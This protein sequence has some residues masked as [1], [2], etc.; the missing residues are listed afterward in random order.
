MR[1]A[2]SSFIFSVLALLLN[3]AAALVVADVATDLKDGVDRARVSI[4]SGQALARLNKLRQIS[5]LTA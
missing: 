1:L 4:D 2:F 5:P 3:A